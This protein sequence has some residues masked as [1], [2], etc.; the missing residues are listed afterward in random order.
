MKLTALSAPKALTAQSAEVKI[1]LLYIATTQRPTSAL[2]AWEM[3]ASLA[4]VNTATALM[5]H[6]TA[7]SA[8]MLTLTSATLALVLTAHPSIARVLNAQDVCPRIARLALELIAQFAK[9]RTASSAMLTISATLALD[10]VASPSF[11]SPLL[12]TSAHLAPVLIA[13]LA[14]VTDASANLLMLPALTAHLKMVAP[15]AED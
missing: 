5:A 4:S 8:L 2:L 6:L 12:S 3:I 14:L 11:V 9:M 1:A 15:P 10:L 13:R 7:M